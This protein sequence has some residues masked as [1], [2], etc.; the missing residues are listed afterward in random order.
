MR[1]KAPIRRIGWGY[2]SL[3]GLAVIQQLVVY[4]KIYMNQ[5]Y[6]TLDVIFSVVS[7]AALVLGFILPVGV[8]VV[9]IFVYLVSYFVWLVTYADVN[10]LTFSWWL[11]IPANVAVAAF[12]KAS[13]VR[14][15][16][17]MDRLQE[18]QDR[19]PEIDLDTSL[20]NKEALTDTVIKQSNLAKRYSEHYGFSMAMFKIEFLPLV[21]ES[22]GSVRYAQ[23]LLELSST[24]QKQIRFE[25]YKFFVDRGR[26]VILC[27]MVNVEYLPVLTQRIKSAMMDLSFIDKKGN[28]LQTV[29]RSGALIFQKENFSKYE[30]IDAVIAALERNTE[31][32]LIGEYI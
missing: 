19:N 15:A 18:M 17:I 31:T 5:S 26:F 29:I 30:D 8:S 6:T 2:A 7:L 16:R 3:I 24:I 32:D 10:V 21:M 25:D 9:V 13:L 12:I 14:S 1:N 20:G 28:E 11:L 22:L 4:L 27:P 23:F